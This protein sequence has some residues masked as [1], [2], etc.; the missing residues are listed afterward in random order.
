[1]WVNATRIT[2]KGGKLSSGWAGDSKR[3]E[4]KTA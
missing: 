4:K 1:V 3:I 2:K